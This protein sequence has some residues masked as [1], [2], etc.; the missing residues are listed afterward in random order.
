MWAFTGP[1]APRII[2][3]RRSHQ[4]LKIAIEPFI[5]PTFECRMTSSGCSVTRD[6]PSAMATALFSCRQTTNCGF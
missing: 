1:V 3:G 2:I 6:Q 4:A 5:N